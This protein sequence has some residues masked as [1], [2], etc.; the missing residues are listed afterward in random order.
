MFAAIDFGIAA[1]GLL[2]IAASLLQ[3]IGGVEPALEMAA[4][5]LAFLILLVAGALSW[6]LD[7]DFVIGELRGS[8]CARS[9]GCGQKVH[10]RSGGQRRRIPSVRILLEAFCVMP[11]TRELRRMRRTTAETKLRD[12]LQPPFS[13]ICSRRA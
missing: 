7:F 9:Y 10:P 12:Y 2:H 4:T 6:F 3:Q 13:P 11:E 8:R 1:P 5:E